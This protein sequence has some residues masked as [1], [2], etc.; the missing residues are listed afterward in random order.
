MRVL[1]ALEKVTLGLF[2]GTCLCGKFGFGGGRFFEPF[3]GG[4]RDDG[5]F[6][7]VSTLVLVDAPQRSAASR[8]GVGCLPTLDAIA[9]ES[10]AVSLNAGGTPGGLAA[11]WRSNRGS[12]GRWTPVGRCRAA[13]G[14]SQSGTGC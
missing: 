10:L 5:A 9:C 8:G 7:D 13:A 4:R 2:G 14:R 1:A 3:F 11:R 12:G 6:A